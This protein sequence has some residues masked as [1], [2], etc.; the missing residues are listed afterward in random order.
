MRRRVVNP[1]TPSCSAIPAQFRPVT[2]LL[3]VRPR[4]E[5][6]I[7]RRRFVALLA[8]CTAGAL[9]VRIVHVALAGRELG[10]NDGLAFHFQ[11]NLIA[12]GSGFI[13]SLALMWGYVKQPTAAHPPL[14]PLLLSAVSWVGF[15]SVLAHQLACAA[16][17]VLA[18]P[19]LGL[20]ANEVAGPEAGLVA[21]GI[22]A[23]YPNL[24]ASD[25][26]VMS[27]SLYVTTIALVLWMLCRLWARP[28][29][30]RAALVGATIGLAALTR[31]EATLLIPL[32]VVPLAVR[33]KTVQP[34]QRAGL[35]AVVLA[36]SAVVVAPW[37]VRNLV[38]F[39]RPVF[40]A[41]D[42]D[43]VVEGANCHATYYGPMLGS[44]AGCP[45]GPLPAGDESVRGAAVRARG[46]RYARAH[47]SRVPIVVAARVG[48]ALDMYRPF[49]GLADIRSRWTRPFAVGFFFALWPFAAVGAMNL[50]RRSVSLIPF[51]APGLLAIVTAIAG[52][53]LWRL[54]V[55]FDDAVIVLAGVALANVRWT[56]HGAGDVPP[57]R[58]L[59]TSDRGSP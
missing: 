17:S 38:T 51:L 45:G 6:Q 53:G 39:D 10:F 20:T 50:R 25:V 29:V 11:A 4:W 14:F 16:M 56:R 55:P 27:E 12:D 58:E 5:P 41:Q 59:A 57:V 2:S 21:A 15:R 13:N 1:Q 30:G 43:T 44:W 19:L 37:V 49:Q 31:A 36:A 35:V 23:I 22:A 18:V 3:A 42:F 47:L 8:L 46:I 34:R 54:R 33:V 24:W 7:A 40:L 48:R 9:V 28:S 52:Y 26:G 32:A